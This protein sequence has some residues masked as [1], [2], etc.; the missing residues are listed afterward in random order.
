MSFILEDYHE[1]L[2]VSSWSYWI[3]LENTIPNFLIQLLLKSLISN[4]I[5]KPAKKNR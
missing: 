5:M 1:V 4:Y 2:Y 3:Y